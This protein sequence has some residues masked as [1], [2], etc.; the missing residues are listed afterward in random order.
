MYGLKQAKIII[1]FPIFISKFR[2]DP[3]KEYD[4]FLFTSKPLKIYIFLYLS[5]EPEIVI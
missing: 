4:Y 5:R 1:T 3:F 2:K